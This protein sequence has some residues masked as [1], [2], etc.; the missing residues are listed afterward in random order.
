M[1]RRLKNPFEGNPFESINEAMQG[2]QV[3]ISDI[4]TDQSTLKG[5]V[6][7]IDTSLATENNTQ[8][9]LHEALQDQ[10]TL[11]QAEISD[12]V[13]EQGTLHTDLQVQL[14]EMQSEIND[15]VTEQDRLHTDLQSQLSV[16]ATQDY[17][18]TQGFVIQTDIDESIADLVTQADIDASAS[19]LQ[20]QIES[21]LLYSNANRPRVKEENPGRRK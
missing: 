18:D 12:E 14:S 19:E 5:R 15:E 1:L 21:F 9:E 17:V 6:D 11:M 3:E 7:R 8:D 16:L 20:A 2:M 10:L 13:A 4:E